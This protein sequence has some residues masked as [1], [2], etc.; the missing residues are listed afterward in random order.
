MRAAARPCCRS[1]HGEGNAL[2]IELTIS[3]CH[4]C[5]F[6][7]AHSGSDIPQQKRWHCRDGCWRRSKGT[8]TAASGLGD[9]KQ[10]ERYARM[11]GENV[12]LTWEF[13]DGAPDSP[14]S[15]WDLRALDDSLP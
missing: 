7:W 9:R 8:Y 5:Q 15:V 4:N 1:A 2:S 11:L 6:S 3:A 12:E 10:A 14:L 13:C